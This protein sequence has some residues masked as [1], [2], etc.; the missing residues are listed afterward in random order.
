M[1]TTLPLTAALTGALIAPLHAEEELAP[2]DVDFYAEAQ[3]IRADMDPYGFDTADG[4]NIN[5]GMWLNSVE[6]GK[7]SRFGLEA[8]FVN[9][10]ELRED[11]MFTRSPTTSEQGAGAS[12]VRVEE[13]TSLKLNGFTLAAVW[14]SPYWLYV[15]GGAYLY[16][17][18]VED[19]Q[20]RVLLDGGGATVDTVNDA[21]E[22]D[23]Q[24]GIAPFVT[25]GVAVPLLE[26]LSFTAEYQYTS[27]ESET[28]GTLGIGLRFTN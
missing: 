3:M 14:Q 5:I 22:S 1:K 7:N 17:F 19:D 6:L 2:P 12:S 13:E 27:L 10:S 20:R 26:K 15:K 4:L 11:S 28:Y 8:G 24:S 16:D 9:Q 23:S 21:P 18:K 25:A